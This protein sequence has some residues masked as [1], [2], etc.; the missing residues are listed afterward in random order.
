MEQKGD[1]AV[2]DQAGFDDDGDE[3]PEVVLEGFPSADD[4]GL[5][6]ASP[7][8]DADTAFG[9]CGTFRFWSIRGMQDGLICFDRYP[10]V[11]PTPFQKLT[12][13]YMRMIV[14]A[15]DELALD[16]IFTSDDLETQKSPF[17]STGIF[18]EFFAPLCKQE[19]KSGVG[20]EQPCNRLRWQ[21]R[22]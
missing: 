10:E 2:R 4:P 1:A 18:D 16:G 9:T 17:F 21:W 13:S 15:H 6:P 3:Q 5:I 12:D 14:R 8:N 11:I 7:P 20:Y 19:M 22:V